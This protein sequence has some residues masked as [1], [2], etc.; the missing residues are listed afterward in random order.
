MGE[1][2]RIVLGDLE[3]GTDAKIVRYPERFTDPRGQDLFDRI[4]RLLA[5]EGVRGLEGIVGL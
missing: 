1:A 3:I 5:D 4:S 2:S